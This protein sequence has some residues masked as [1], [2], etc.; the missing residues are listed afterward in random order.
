MQVTLCEDPA[1]IDDTDALTQGLRLLQVMCRVQNR[2][3]VGVAVSVNFLKFLPGLWINTDS[4]LV[5]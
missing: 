3:A 1:I 4:W 5:L 2:R